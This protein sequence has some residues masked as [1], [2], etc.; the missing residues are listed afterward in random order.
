[1]S[2]KLVLVIG[3]LLVSALAEKQNVEPEKPSQSEKLSKPEKVSEPEKEASAEA[4]AEVNLGDVKI[5]DKNVNKK[6]FEEIENTEN[7]L[8]ASASASASFSFNFEEFLAK[9]FKACQQN[10]ESSENESN[11]EEGNKNEENKQ[12]AE[13]NAQSEENP[14]EEAKSP[15]IYS[16]NVHARSSASASASSSFYF[17]DPKEDEVNDDGIDD[18]QKNVTEQEQSVDAES[19]K[20]D[21]HC[22][23]QN[24]E[25]KEQLQT[26]DETQ[27]EE[28]EQ[29]FNTH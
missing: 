27:A 11:K 21:E 2:I 3:F 9:W 23:Q 15:C 18:L 26:E 10:K 1:M 20:V 12:E 8:K 7:G 29:I 25:D 4:K 19:N 16:Y 13:D 24:G 17:Y 6:V 5:E 22:N 14:I 28:V